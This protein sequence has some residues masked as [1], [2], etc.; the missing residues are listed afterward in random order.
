MGFEDLGEAGKAQTLRSVFD[1]MQEV[2]DTKEDRS[3]PITSCHSAVGYWIAHEE[4]VEPTDEIVVLGAEKLGVTHSIL[5]RDDEII[6]DSERSAKGRGIDTTYDMATGEY[7]TTRSPMNDTLNVAYQTVMRMSVG[8]F[9]DRCAAESEIEPETAP[10]IDDE[11]T[12]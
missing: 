10:L 8:E 9:L 3:F 5:M 2:L 11:L 1:I 4:R 7:K 12:I 6:G